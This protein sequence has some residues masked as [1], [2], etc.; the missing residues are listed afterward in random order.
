MNDLIEF[1]LI[2]VFILKQKRL[3][4][5]VFWQKKFP[6]DNHLATQKSNTDD[7]L[8]GEQKMGLFNDSEFET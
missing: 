6:L 1:S 5:V 3:Q 4:S 7:M 8:K 2:T